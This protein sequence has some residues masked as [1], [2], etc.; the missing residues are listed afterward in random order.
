MGY[1]KNKA[2]VY[3]LIIKL[4]PIICLFSIIKAQDLYAYVKI[5]LIKLSVYANK[6]KK[7]INFRSRTKDKLLLCFIINPSLRLILVKLC[8]K[9]LSTTKYLCRS[10][11]IFYQN[12]FSFVNC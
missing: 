1:S 5:E 4:I 10:E 2:I 11:R 12:I 9:C 8:L 7:S 6:N 3:E